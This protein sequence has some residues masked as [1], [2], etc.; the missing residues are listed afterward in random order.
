MIPFHLIIEHFVLS[1]LFRHLGF[2][3]DFS[4][5]PILYSKNLIIKISRKNDL[6]FLTKDFIQSC[7]LLMPFCF[8]YQKDF[9]TIFGFRLN[10]YESKFH[11]ISSLIEYHY[12]VPTY[13]A[14]LYFLE[15]SFNLFWL[16]NITSLQYL[17]KS[18]LP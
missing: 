8:G 1:F 3:L 5:F 15:K 6:F 14:I 9:H 18:F 4:V 16:Q 10:F 11:L 12:C 17:I 7:S 13:S 2:Q